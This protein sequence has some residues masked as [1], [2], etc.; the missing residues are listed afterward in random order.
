MAGGSALPGSG[1][2]DDRQRRVHRSPLLFTAPVILLGLLSCLAVWEVLRGNLSPSTRETWPWRFSAL[3][4]EALASLLAVSLGFVFARAQYS[5]AA[6]PIIGWSGL[7][8]SDTHSMNSKFVWIVRILNGG[9]HSAILERVDYHVQPKGEQVSAADIEWYGY[10]T[11]V[12]ELESLGL[13]IGKDFYL[14]PIGAGSPLG[15]SSEHKSLT[16]ARL[17]IPALSLLDNIYIRVRVTDAV[18]DSHERILHC[19]RGA[20]IEIRS[21]L[22]ADEQ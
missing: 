19:L 10:T 13:Q 15:I 3:N 12:A 20:E 9:M 16:A 7:A 2:L 14:N 11:V 22:A 8:S 18:G 17:S 1:H 21:A 4:Q 6:R 5:R